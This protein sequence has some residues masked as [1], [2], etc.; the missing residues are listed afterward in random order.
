[1]KIVIIGSGYVGLVTGACL[2]EV[3]NHVTCYD[4]DTK[5]IN[6]LQNNI[7]PIYEPGLKKIIR[8][9]QKA[10]RIYFTDQ[11]TEKISTNADIIF[12]AVGTPPD[13][14]GSADI[15]HVL[16]AAK[17]IGKNINNY[18]VIVTKSTVPIGTGHRIKK[19]ILNELKK[20]DIKCDF[21]VASNPEFLKEGAAVQDF[22][23]PDRIVIGCDNEKAINLLKELYIPFNRSRDK[24]HIM[25][26]ASSELTKYAS[27]CILA[28]KISLMNEIA[29][30]ADHVGANINQVRL[31]MGADPRIGHHFIYPGVGYGGSC[32][33]K[34]VRALA[35]IGNKAG[36]AT[37]LL[38]AV[39][40]VNTQQKELLFKK[41]KYH[42]PSLIDKTIAIWGLTFKPNTDDIREAPSLTL[43][44]QLLDAGSHIKAYCPKGMPAV[45]KIFHNEKMIT[46]VNCAEEAVKDCDGLALV[47]EWKQF[48]SVDFSHLKSLMKQAVLFDGRN[49]WNPEKIKSAGFHYYGIGVR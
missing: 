13:E 12:I 42:Y 43:I 29:N 6:A 25:D 34:D 1:M 20:R 39:E 40:S 33:P 44:Q 36:C 14:D 2:A 19:T 24:L 21:D 26:I 30:I 9:N 4:V 48:W 28:T 8:K 10:K 49:I 47:T 17:T 46:F 38:D 18:T 41:I 3:G 7:I 32:F 5:K 37:E 27:N 22:M 15:Q 11:F 35:H 45:K 16:S 23:Y 31:A